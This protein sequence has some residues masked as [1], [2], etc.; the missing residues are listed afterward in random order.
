VS[1]LAVFDRSAASERDVVIVS[2][3]SGGTVVQR[4][5]DGIRL[6]GSFGVARWDGSGWHLEPPIGRWMS[7]A[8]HIL[9]AGGSPHQREVL[10]Q[11]LQFAV[12]DLGAS[13]I[14]ALLVLGVGEDPPIEER[15][16]SPPPLA[17]LQPAALGPLRHVLAQTDGAAIFD[18]GGILRHLGARLVPSLRAEGTTPA[19]GGTRHTSARRFSFDQPDA[20]VVAVSDDGPV[21]VFCGGEMVGRSPND[22]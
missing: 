9:L 13:G 14:G 22:T 2:E 18:V 3:A 21:T 5:A 1:A 11:L 20:V 6:A 7:D 12:H 15:L 17:L 4:R 19:F 16:P 8:G 10:D